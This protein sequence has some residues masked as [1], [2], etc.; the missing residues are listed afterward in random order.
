MTRREFIRQMRALDGT[1]K[2]MVLRNGKRIRLRP[3][4]PCAA[5]WKLLISPDRKKILDFLYEDIL[6]VLP[7][8]PARRRRKAN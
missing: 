6:E 5:G 3:M 4:Q 7:L 8:T 2:V 1:P